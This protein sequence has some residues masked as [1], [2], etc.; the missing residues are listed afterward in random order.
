[1]L[2]RHPIFFAAAAMTAVVAAANVSVAFPVGSGALARW[3]TWGAF[4]YPLTFLINDL[5][6]RFFGLAIAQRAIWLSFVPAALIS[7]G[8]TGE[9]RIAAASVLAY[10]TA[11]LMDAS[12]FDWL[13][14]GWWWRAPL[15]S[16]AL[17]SIADTVIFYGLAFAGTPASS[18]YFGWEAPLWIGWAVG[19]VGFKILFAA[20]L[21]LPYRIAL[22]ARR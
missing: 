18:I 3:L 22:L 14:H 21:L 7:W 15:I 6:N 17:A 12:L 1:M 4:V 5:T 8:L 9:I 16:S 11:Q 19:D 2:A 20:L 10:I 13:R